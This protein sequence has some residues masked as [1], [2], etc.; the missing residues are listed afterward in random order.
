MIKQL[1]PK[2]HFN[3]YKMTDCKDNQLIFLIEMYRHYP[4]NDVTEF[5]K[6]GYLYELHFNHHNELVN[7]G[8][9]DFPEMYESYLAYYQKIIGVSVKELDLSGCNKITDE[10]LKYLAG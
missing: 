2:Y 4:T 10:G 7:H 9:T 8:L 3:N 6:L 5:D 1:I